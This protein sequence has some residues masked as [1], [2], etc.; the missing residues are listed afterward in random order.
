MDGALSFS[1]AVFAEKKINYFLSARRAGFS[2]TVKRG[3]RP[4]EGLT[5]AVRKR[6]DE[7]KDLSA[8][9]RE[10]EAGGKIS[11][12]EQ[13]A[14]T[15]SEYIK[16]INRCL[17]F[18]NADWRAKAVF[19]LKDGELVLTEIVKTGKENV[20]CYSKARNDI[21]IMA[22]E[23][24]L[25][26]SVSLGRC[27]RATAMRR[28]KEIRKYFLAEGI[29]QK[30]KVTAYR[31]D[32]TYAPFEIAKDCRETERR[33]MHRQNSDADRK[34]FSKRL[35]LQKNCCLEEASL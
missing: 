30:I 3:G 4:D 6:S 29:S 7:E 10:I 34:N 32:G 2:V 26:G 21:E 5:I 31:Q 1:D 19:S 33:G 22:E 12:D 14:S 16:R 24:L 35:L 23:I 17:D 9:I 27:A 13:P 15:A 25:N 11:V 28:A 18:L 8:V 20:R